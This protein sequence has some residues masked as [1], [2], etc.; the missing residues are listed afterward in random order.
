MR[1]AFRYC[2]IKLGS[3]ASQSNV[4]R[5]RT[6]KPSS[7]AIRVYSSSKFDLGNKPHQSYGDLNRSSKREKKRILVDYSYYQ[8]YI[9]A[10]YK[11]YQLEIDYS[12]LA[13]DEDAVVSV[14]WN[15]LR[16]E[17]EEVVSKEPLMQPLIDEAILQ[18]STFRDALSFRLATKLGGKLLSSDQWVKIFEDAYTVVL[19]PNQADAYDLE[20]AA[21]LDLVAIKDRDPACDTLFTAFMFFKGYKA[22]QIYRV[23]HVLWRVG[24]KE[25]ASLMQSRTSEVFAVDIHPAAVIGR[26]LM[27][28]HATGLVIGETAAVGD[29]CSFLHGIT[30]GATGKEKGDRHPKVGDNVN[31]GCNASLIGNIKV[32]NNA[33]IGAG[34]VVLK[35][36]PDFCTAVGSPA[37]ILIPK[38][39]LDHSQHHNHIKEPPIKQ[40]PVTLP[41]TIEQV[42]PQPERRFSNPLVDP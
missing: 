19:P 12:K 39:L 3:D 25:I 36:V 33:K 42:H 14:V 41:H 13:L 6:I 31:I 23:S 32:G 35:N 11:K 9:S 16:K 30:L 27:I 10:F 18:H 21:C 8:N 24:R 28:D 1:S 4:S 40:A 17:A 38:P 20:N 37:K 29:N 22:L 26:G 2:T 34:S 15:T 5:L 7:S